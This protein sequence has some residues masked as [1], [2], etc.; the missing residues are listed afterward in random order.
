M[1]ELKEIEKMIMANIT[2]YDSLEDYGKHNYCGYTP[3]EIEE[4]FNHEVEEGW[5]MDISYGIDHNENTTHNTISSILMD[6][7]ATD[8]FNHSIF[9]DEE[10]DTT[11]KRTLD[12]VLEFTEIYKLFTVDNKLYIEL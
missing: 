9:D 8:F 6:M 12:W 1:L 11:E 5:L 10:I 4:E 2:R 7:Y 3:Q